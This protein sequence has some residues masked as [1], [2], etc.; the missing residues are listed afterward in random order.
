MS[1]FPYLVALALINQQGDRLMPIGGKSLKESID[2]NNVLKSKYESIALELLLRIF[3][4]TDELPN[5]REN[6]D[7]SLLLIQIPI[8]S[9]QKMLPSLKHTWIKSGD[10]RIFL[11]DLNKICDHIWALNFV[12]YEGLKL[13]LLDLENT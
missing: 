8:E 9:M 1:T 13:N 7:N 6:G 4:R 11:T 10:T 3:E 5:K 2:P 12:R